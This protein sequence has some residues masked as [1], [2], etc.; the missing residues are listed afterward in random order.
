MEERNGPSSNQKPSRHCHDLSYLSFPIVDNIFRSYEMNKKRKRNNIEE[1]RE[2]EV[3]Q[4]KEYQMAVEDTNQTSI[5]ITSI[6]PLL[7]NYISQPE[8]KVK[9]K[10]EEE[11]F[12]TQITSQR[13]L[14]LKNN[15]ETNMMTTTSF[16]PPS[17]SSRTSEPLN[18]IVIPKVILE[19][20]PQQFSTKEI[21]Q[22]NQLNDTLQQ[23]KQEQAQ[24]IQLVQQQHQQQQLS[25]DL[26]QSTLPVQQSL[27]QSTQL[28]QQQEQLTHLEKQLELT[29]PDFFPP[30][31][32]SES[33]SSTPKSSEFENISIKLYNLRRNASIYDIKKLLEGVKGI[34]R[35]T[36]QPISQTCLVVLENISSA[37][38]LL[39]YFKNSIII[40]NNEAKKE[41]WGEILQKSQTPIRRRDT[42]QSSSTRYNYYCPSSSTISYP[43]TSSIIAS[44]NSSTN[45]S[46]DSISK[47]FPYQIKQE[48]GGE[49]RSVDCYYKDR[50]KYERNKDCDHRRTP[51]LPLPTV[52]TPSPSFSS[53]T[54]LSPQSSLSSSSSWSD[55][56]KRRDDKVVHSNE[57]NKTGSDVDNNVKYI[58]QEVT[59]NPPPHYHNNN[60]NKHSYN[61][62]NNYNRHNHYH[63]NNNSNNAQRNKYQNNNYYRNSNPNN[64]NNNCS[65]SGNNV[66]NQRQQKKK[67]SEWLDLAI[68]DF[69]QCNSN[70]NDD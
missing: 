2:V 8:F 44:A 55:N 40:D 26:E 9:E 7:D 57:R 13:Q 45:T 30:L 6:D 70:I 38:Y 14:N 19:I 17:S 22:Q 64:N 68:N 63:P 20:I 34:K 21:S 60:N 43:L 33:T 39:N 12:S 15:T 4:E 1:D 59:P 65:N 67:T 54:T 37:N 56:R 49:N 42:N 66:Q 41:V 47:E 58:K 27:Q 11:S 36:T 32:D 48:G 51:I 62:N 53:T 35:I 69:L 28:E 3:N 29:L 16:P 24:P 25:V 10:E 18:S 5:T 31:T 23:S 52:P 50:D 61:T 46:S